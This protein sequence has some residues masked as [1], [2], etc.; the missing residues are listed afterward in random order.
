MRYSARI[1]SDTRISPWFPW[2][3]VIAAEWIETANNLIEYTV[4]LVWLTA[5]VLPCQDC[6]HFGL[7][8]F[9]VTINI[10]KTKKI[11]V[12]RL[13]SHLYLSLFFALVSGFWLGIKCILI[14]CFVFYSLYCFLCI[15]KLFCFLV[16]QISQ[17][18]YSNSFS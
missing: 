17:I 7:A 16:F 6:T 5:H 18:L 1:S 13:V 9:P 11:L 14:S 10:N 15:V 12:S 4:C 3:F 8:T 2:I